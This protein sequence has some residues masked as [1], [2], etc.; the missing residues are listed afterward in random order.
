LGFFGL[1]EATGLVMAENSILRDSLDANGSMIVDEN[2]RV[3]GRKNILAIKDT[4][5]IKIQEALQ[6][7]TFDNNSQDRCGD[8]SL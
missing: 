8:W 4:I 5:N 7:A 6:H 2:L 1:R 3:K